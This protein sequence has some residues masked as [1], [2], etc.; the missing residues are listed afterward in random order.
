M[1]SP[2][3]TMPR[4]RSL[5]LFWC[6]VIG[7]G[8]AL[9]GCSVFKPSVVQRGSLVEADDYNKLKVGETSRSDVMDALGSPTGRATF[10][11]NTWIYVSMTHVLVPISF[12][13][14]RKQDVVVLTFDQNGILRNL[15]SLHKNDARYVT[16]AAGRTPTPG[17]KI[18]IMQQIL[19]NVGRYNPLS[20][21][22]STY[23]GSM[24]PMNSMNGGPGHGGSGNSLP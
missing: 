16:M 3:D 11:D 10:D 24:G 22:T 18:N 2:K 12:P 1:R 6:A 7:A 13:Q 23:G 4:P 14:V 19:G 9:S 8:V 5:R 15:R 17:T 20:Q 21:M